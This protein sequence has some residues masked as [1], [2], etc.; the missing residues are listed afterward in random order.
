MENLTEELEEDKQPAVY[1]DF[2]FITK[3]ELTK[4]SLTHLVGT[5]LLRGY[6]HG[7]FVD[8]RL[9]LKA[10]RLAEPFAYEEYRA[11]K[12]KQK[13]Q[14]KTGDRITP[15]KKVPKVNRELA[16]RLET[17]AGIATIP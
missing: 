17:D 12:M 5:N 7:F 1:D 9:Y 15:R 14:E 3:E 11:E 8:Y 6:M 16:A 13:L 4:L 10:K 2:K